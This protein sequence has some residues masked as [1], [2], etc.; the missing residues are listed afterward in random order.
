[1]ARTYRRKNRKSQFVE[2]WNSYSEHIRNWY[3]DRNPGKTDKE[4]IHLHEV[5][6][7][8]DNHPG[9]WS[10]TSAF[11]KGLYIKVKNKNRL[12]LIRCLRTEDEFVE[13]PLKRDSGYQYF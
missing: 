2:A 10:P 8:C 1:M 9:E 13:I 7:H 6:Y 11:N 12:N 5:E 4:I 3:R